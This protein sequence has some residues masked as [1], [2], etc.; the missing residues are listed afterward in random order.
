VPREVGVYELLWI[1]GKIV[2]RQIIKTE[3]ASGVL[4]VTKDAIEKVLDL[5]DGDDG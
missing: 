5:V 2:V 3:V 4:G 1:V